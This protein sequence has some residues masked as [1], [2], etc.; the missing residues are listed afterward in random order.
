MAEVV[1]IMGPS[2]SGKSTSI[3]TL[4]PSETFVINTLGKR[5]PFRGSNKLYTTWNK[6]TNP[7]GNMVKTSNSHNTL[8]WLDFIDKNHPAIKN[9][10]I[11]D[12][13]H[14]SSM[15][16][17][18]RIGEGGWNKFND[19][20]A[21]MVSIVERAKNMRDDIT[22]FILHHTKEDG[23]G[24]LEDKLTKAMTLGKMIDEKMSSYEAF[25]TIVLLARKKKD[26]STINYV[27]LT[28][29]ANSTAKTPMGMFEDAEI[30]NDLAM[31]K[32]AI[33]CY[34]DEQDCK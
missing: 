11:E 26:E 33:T 3:R 29:D 30:P 16:Y 13:T 7:D 10:V 25:F 14:Q 24:I 21:N 17:I 2:G 19:I 27:F 6:E 22:V 5:L 18:R 8:K 15:E 34:Y 20:A 9:V 31:V 23:D 12:N 32:S 4:N 28:Q 1:L